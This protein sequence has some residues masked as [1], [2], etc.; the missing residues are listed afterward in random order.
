VPPEESFVRIEYC[1]S[2]RYE[3]YLIYDPSILS[4]SGSYQFVNINIAL[5]LTLVLFLSWAF[6]MIPYCTTVSG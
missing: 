3:V 4:I 2:K 1:T 5:L 6:E